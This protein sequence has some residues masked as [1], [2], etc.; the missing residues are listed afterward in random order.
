MVYFFINIKMQI[1]S[2][3]PSHK[4]SDDYVIWGDLSRLLDAFCSL[5][6]Q[7]MESQKLLN[8]NSEEDWVSHWTLGLGSV[9]GFLAIIV[10]QSKDRIKS[11]VSTLQS[12]QRTSNM[13]ELQAIQPVAGITGHPVR[14]YSGY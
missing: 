7:V 9:F 6:S 13:V 14:A 8:A 2:F 11:M 5:Q 10:L 12:Q 4:T 1:G 3:L